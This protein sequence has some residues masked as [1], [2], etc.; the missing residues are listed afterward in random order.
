MG[1]TIGNISNWKLL[2]K[3]ALIFTRRSILGI[4][5]LRPRFFFYTYICMAMTCVLASKAFVALKLFCQSLGFNAF[6]FFLYLNFESRSLQNIGLMILPTFADSASFI[7]RCIC[8]ICSSSSYNACATSLWFYEIVTH[9]SICRPMSTN[10]T[11]LFPWSLY[12]CPLW[13]W[14]FLCKK[15]HI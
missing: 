10:I 5:H 4:C 12:I 2:K 14:T 9:I 6:R 15:N 13:T 3:L 11:F 8:M 1:Q 7:V